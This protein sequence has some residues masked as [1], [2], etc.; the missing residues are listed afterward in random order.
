[1]IN[2]TADYYSAILIFY[3]NNSYIYSSESIHLLNGDMS[4]ENYYTTSGSS[5]LLSLREWLIRSSITDSSR[6]QSRLFLR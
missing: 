2:L 4:L 5:V 1:V 6:L 3:S